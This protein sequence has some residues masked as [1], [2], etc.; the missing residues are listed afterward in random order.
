MK[1]ISVYYNKAEAGKSVVLCLL[2]AMSLMGVACS[3][4]DP[5]DREATNLADKGLCANS[6]PKPCSQDNDCET[7]AGQLC[8]DYGE[9]GQACVA[10][11]ACPRFCEADPECETQAGEACLRTTLLS[12]DK[13]CTSPDEALKL[14]AGDG[15]CTEGDKCCTIYQEPFCLP[16][17]LCPKS[18]GKSAECDT[19][20]GEVCCTTVG[21][22]DPTLSVKG[23]CLHPD[24][25]TC[26]AACTT[27]ADCDNKAGELCCNAVCSTSCPKECSSSS[28]CTNQLCCKTRAVDSPWLSGKQTPVYP[29]GGIAPPNQPNPGTA[30]PGYAGSDQCC[31]AGDPC[32]RAGN[33]LCDCYGMCAWDSGDCSSS[34]P[35]FCPGYRF[36]DGCCQKDDPCNWSND[37]ACDCDGMCQWDSGDCSGYRRPPVDTVSWCDGCN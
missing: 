5:S 36:G 26:P 29:S 30:C 35:R 34:D 24:K 23:L 33:G 6:C 32:G 10:A 21:V 15:D 20:M 17:E 4:G 37:G 31:V 19:G 16:P 25:F 22:N 7:A 1:M 9:V 3:G 18:C 13:V 27:S 11:A 2:F 28:E 14:C 8:C 12:S